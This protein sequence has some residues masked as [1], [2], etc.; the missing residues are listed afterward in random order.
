M[1]GFDQV[2]S[3]AGII[4]IFLVLHLLIGAATLSL[5]PRKPLFRRVMEKVG[6]EMD[7]RLNR[8]GRSSSD[9]FV[10]GVIA[11]IIIGGSAF[12]IGLA[13]NRFAL[14]PL[15]WIVTLFFLFMNISVMGPLA[16]MWQAAKYLRDNNLKAAAAAVQPFTACS[17]DKGDAHIIARRTLEAGAISL[18]DFFMAPVFWFLL[19]QTQGLALYV[20]LSAL[21][22]AVGSGDSRH[23]FFGKFI[24]G[25]DRIMNYI[26]ARCVAVLIAFG[27]IFVAR[28]NPVRGF[29]VALTQAHVMRPVYKG[30]LVAA[31]AGG[32]G[33]TLGEGIKHN[34]KT[35][36]PQGWIGP[37]G[38]T[39][40]VTDKDLRRGVMLHYV[41]FLCIFCIIAIATTIK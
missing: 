10:R 25:L 22:E 5:P 26:T 27:A 9:L 19:F 4:L 1:P 41:V 17:L 39:A 23:I 8:P 7:R 40:K 13:V 33:V 24:R 12:I 29:M 15:G 11:C 6:R 21:A 2:A 38:T 3:S 18:N 14:Y 28:A 32:I 35:P 30:V 16:M 37:A 34:I 20:A 31:M 36:Q